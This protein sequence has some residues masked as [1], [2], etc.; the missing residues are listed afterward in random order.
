MKYHILSEGIFGNGGIHHWKIRHLIKR[1]RR[2]T[3][4]RSAIP[5]D[6]SK[7]IP[8]P[9]DPIKNQGQ[10]SS[11]GRQAA[12]YAQ[13]IFLRRLG[14]DEGEISAKSG[15]GRYCAQGGGMTVD[16]VETDICA[17]GANL[18]KKVPSYYAMGGPLSEAMYEDASWETPA[19]MAD[20]LKR[21][22]FTPLNVEI[23]KDA[24]AEAIRDYGAILILFKG[25]N[26]N[27]PNNW[28]TPNPDPPVKTNKNA[29]WGH[30]VCAAGT[31]TGKIAFFQSWGN[32]VGDHGIQYF[33]DKYINSGYIVDCI[34]FVSD[35]N[36]ISLPPSMP[37]WNGVLAWF[38][39]LWTKQAIA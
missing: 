14:I 39:S 21:A 1:A 9:N 27:Q 20:A 16:A 28:T 24:I 2:S 37:V 17:Y 25:Q 10:S 38:R 5:F 22:G 18:E 34:T 35:R 11:C 26:G 4:G 30:W 29:L 12:A 3:L 13:R 36:I 23:N 32:T 6:W 31:T 8:I 19:T 7:P 15:Y 33:D